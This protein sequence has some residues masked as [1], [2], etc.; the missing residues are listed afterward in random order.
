MKKPP[1][2]LRLFRLLGRPAPAA[3]PAACHPSDD[4]LLHLVLF[5]HTAAI[6]RHLGL[7]VDQL[8]VLE[9]ERTL[10]RTSGQV[11]ARLAALAARYRMQ[12]AAFAHRLLP[13]DTGDA[14]RT[15]LA[16]ADPFPPERLLALQ[17]AVS[18]WGRT[19][20]G[21]PFRTLFDYVPLSMG[22]LPA[23]LDRGRVQRTRRT[24]WGFK[25]SPD[26]GSPAAHM[27]S[28]YRVVRAVGSCIRDT[29]G[30][31]ASRL[32]LFCIPA[33]SVDGHW[34]RYREFSLLLCRYTGM[35]GSF[36]HVQV[37]RDRQA[38]HTGGTA[39][40]NWRSD[41]D[42]FRGRLVLVFDDIYTTGRSLEDAAQRLR[43][44]GAR[45]VAAHFIGRTVS[46]E[47]IFPDTDKTL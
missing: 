45:V 9:E 28:L 11:P 30:S 14:R 23:G 36:R 33:S 13:L 39:S 20:S 43:L 44:V 6:R 42:F 5:T 10:F 7:T 4:R 24:V 32:T 34:L 2:L 40:C 19:P 25:H 21:I 16:P 8:F 46:R 31:D 15:V 26:S 35:T 47:E 3:A 27:R 41:A 37:V 1:L 12:I 17:A 38:V 29:F 18:G 22:D